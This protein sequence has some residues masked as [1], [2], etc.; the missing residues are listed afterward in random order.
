MARAPTSNAP[1]ISVTHKFSDIYSANVTVAPNGII[2]NGGAFGTGA[3]QGS[4]AVK[5]AFVQAHYFDAWIPQVGAEK[6][7]AA[8]VRRGGLAFRRKR[9]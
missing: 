3:L 1:T 9:A 6:T 5:Y 2:L 7:A 4:E 8:F